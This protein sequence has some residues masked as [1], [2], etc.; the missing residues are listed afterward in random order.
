MK[1]GRSC[2]GRPSAYG[3]NKLQ[4]AVRQTATISISVHRVSGVPH[5]A[6]MKLAMAAKIIP[7]DRIVNANTRIEIVTKNGPRQWYFER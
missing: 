3:N 7:M 4:N 6:I 1:V 5:A 2:K